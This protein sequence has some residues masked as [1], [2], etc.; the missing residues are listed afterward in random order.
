MCFSMSEPE[1]SAVQ[2]HVG[3]SRLPVGCMQVPIMDT[4]CRRQGHLH[5]EWL[6]YFTAF[7]EL[8]NGKVHSE[9]EKKRGKYFTSC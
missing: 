2:M 1:C 9:R 7:T 4:K 8:K 3:A 6:G 5:L